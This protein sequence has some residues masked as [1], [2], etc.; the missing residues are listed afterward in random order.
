MGKYIIVAIVILILVVIVYYRFISAWCKV[1]VLERQYQEEREQLKPMYGVWRICYDA[2]LGMGGSGNSAPQF[3]ETM[4]HL[5]FAV[6]T[7][8]AVLDA[9]EVQYGKKAV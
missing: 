3:A 9:M 2:P 7:A 5:S 4:K 1:K 6:N 8:V